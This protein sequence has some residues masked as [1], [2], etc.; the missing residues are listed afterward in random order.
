MIL[1]GV[2]SVFIHDDVGERR[3][4][5][6]LGVGSPR[7]DS[8]SARELMAQRSEPFENLEEDHDGLVVAKKGTLVVKRPAPIQT[9]YLTIPRGIGGGGAPKVPQNSRTRFQQIDARALQLID[10]C[11]CVQSPLW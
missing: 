2:V 9:G 8:G 10:S 5:L 4:N 6:D 3:S 1:V 11:A 7:F